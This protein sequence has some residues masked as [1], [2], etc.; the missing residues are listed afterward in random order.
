MS[1]DPRDPL[2]FGFIVSKAVGDAPARNRLRRRYRA[3]GR[4]LVDAELHGHDVVVRALPGAA[5]LSWESLTAEFR[6]GVEAITTGR[7]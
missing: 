4:S 5:E 7:A 2:R 6:R 1:R 3:L